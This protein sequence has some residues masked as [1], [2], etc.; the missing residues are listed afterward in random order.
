MSEIAMIGAMK[1]FFAVQSLKYKLEFLV[2]KYCGGEVSTSTSADNLHGEINVETHFECNHGDIPHEGKEHNY[3]Y[4]LDA[5]EIVVIKFDS[6]ELMNVYWKQFNDKSRLWNL[7]KNKN[8]FK[9]IKKRQGQREHLCTI[10]GK[11]IETGTYV[12]AE[13]VTGCSFRGRHFSNTTYIHDECWNHEIESTSIEV[14]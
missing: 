5:S 3:Y 9:V 6:E 11:I 1:N 10:C 13:T 2:C 8:Q 12:H 14:E 7:R 4:K